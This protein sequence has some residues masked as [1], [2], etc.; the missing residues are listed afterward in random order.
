M[1]SST[2]VD[3][4]YDES[5]S[6][7]H[8][9]GISE[10][11][12]A[13]AAGDSFR[14]ALILAAASYFEHRVS[15]CVLEFVDERANG[16]GLVVAFV[17]NKAVSRQ[18]HTWFKWDDT[19]ANQFFGLFGSDFK[20]KMVD[21]IKESEELKRSVRAF[22]EVGNER[23]KLVHQDFASFSLEKTLEEIYELYSLALLFVEGLSTFLREC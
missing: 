8:T 1:G 16:S 3:R 18:Y 14:K 22:L 17:K 7:I 23:N 19:N 13:V 12:L 11:S 15:S 5:V 10:P 20:Q 6:V 9:L 21:R 2:P 4:L